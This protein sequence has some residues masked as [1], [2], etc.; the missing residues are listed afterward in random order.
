MIMGVIPAK[1]GIQFIENSGLR[2][3][4]GMTALEITCYRDIGSLG[5][6]LNTKSS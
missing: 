3:K 5:A 4:F 1:A 6:R 2:I